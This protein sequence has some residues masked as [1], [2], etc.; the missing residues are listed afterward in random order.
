MRY[1]M[2]LLDLK[3]VRQAYE[4]S[5]YQVPG[6]LKKFSNKGVNVVLLS[7]ERRSKQTDAWL[8]AEELDQYNPIFQEDTVKNKFFSLLL[9]VSPINWKQFFVRSLLESMDAGEAPKA[10]RIFFVDANAKN[11]KAVKKLK[12]ERLVICD[13]LAD[14]ANKVY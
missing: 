4:Q 8:K 13:S 6:T 2:A 1:K 14:M 5:E 7:S 10:D 11:R 12:D 3:T 9:T